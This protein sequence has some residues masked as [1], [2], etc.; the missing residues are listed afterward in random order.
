MAH[1]TPSQPKPEADW[2]PAFIGVGSN[3]GDRM[4]NVAAAVTL[5][6]ET[7][8]VRLIRES[9]LYET[10]AVGGPEGA[11]PFLNGAVEIATRLS[12][13]ELLGRLLEIERS[14][15]RERRVKWEPRPI[16]LD[17][18]LFGQQITSSIDLVIPHPLM[19]E[20]RFVLEP[21]AEIAPD[22]VHPVL[23]MTV[24]GLLDNI[25]R[26]PDVE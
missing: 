21:L 24:K 1:S 23:Q 6:A 7:P 10:A 9:S 13:A 18:L 26:R 19:H 20:R 11:P 14:L 16:D 4:A 2:S 12:P 5:L 17:I 3:L 8:G 15:G 22:A 25:D